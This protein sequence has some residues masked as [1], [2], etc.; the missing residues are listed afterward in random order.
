MHWNRHIESSGSEAP[1]Y[2]RPPSARR[3]LFPKPGIMNVPRSAGHRHRKERPPENRNCCQPASDQTMVALPESGLL[4]FGEFDSPNGVSKICEHA[5]IEPDVSRTRLEVCRYRRHQFGHWQHWSTTPPEWNTV[6][7]PACA[8]SRSAHSRNCD[9]MRLPLS[10]RDQKPQ[11]LDISNLV[12]S[13]QAELHV[14]MNQP[15]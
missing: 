8:R 5:L 10:S 14:Q 9:Q 15:F 12:S 13:C 6:A 7:R 11:A 1:K 2:E 3:C 4:N